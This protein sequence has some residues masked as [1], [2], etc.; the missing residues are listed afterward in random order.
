MQKKIA[1]KYIKS[2]IFVLMYL[3]FPKDN[4]CKNDKL[5]IKTKPVFIKQSIQK[6]KSQVAYRRN[7]YYM[8]VL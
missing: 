7:V 6:I 8:H 5:N 1:K 4:V 2:K 3:I